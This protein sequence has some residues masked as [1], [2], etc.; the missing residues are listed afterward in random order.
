MIKAS[1]ITQC[2]FRAFI[3]EISRQPHARDLH[4]LPR[5]PVSET[6]HRISPSVPILLA[7]LSANVFSQSLSTSWRRVYK[8]APRSY[9]LFCTSRRRQGRGAVDARS[10]PAEDTSRSFNSSVCR[11]IMRIISRGTTTRATT[12]QRQRRQGRWGR[13]RWGTRVVHRGRVHLQK[14]HVYAHK[15]TYIRSRVVLRSS[16]QD[17][18]M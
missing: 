8:A 14:T 4:R 12:I 9:D 3:S 10:S 15:H 13:E 18:Y 6:R 16:A 17:A 11:P 2:S 7:V 5:I 1:L